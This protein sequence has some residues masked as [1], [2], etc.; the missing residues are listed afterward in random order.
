M[1]ADIVTEVVKEHKRRTCWRQPFLLSDENG[2]NVDLSLT[3]GHGKTYFPPGFA[4]PLDSSMDL[5]KPH[6]AVTP[7]R[8]VNQPDKYPVGTVYQFDNT[9]Y[10]GLESK[11]MIISAIQKAWPG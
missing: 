1:N 4:S 2:G 10:N 9:I 5:G 11:D 3:T 8:A 6:S 7:D